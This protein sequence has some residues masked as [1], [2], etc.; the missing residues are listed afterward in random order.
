MRAIVLR[1]YDGTA[2]SLAI[3]EIQVPRPGLAPDKN[4]AAKDRKAEKYRR[5]LPSPPNTA[6][7]YNVYPVI[8]NKI[9]ATVQRQINREHIINRPGQIF[10]SSVIEKA[11]KYYNTSV[12]C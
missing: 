8:E 6:G 4:A 5:T 11:C 10:L 9:T 12:K 7:S 1:D 2:D 3:S